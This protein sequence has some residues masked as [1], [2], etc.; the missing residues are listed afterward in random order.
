M[1]RQTA[2][3]ATAGMAVLAG[4]D[5]WSF[6]E[7]MALGDLEASEVAKP[8]ADEA[9][10]LRRGWNSERVSGTE[11]RERLSA[12]AGAGAATAV[13]VHSDGASPPQSPST[14]PPG[15]AQ[16]INSKGGG[17]RQRGGDEGPRALLGGA[18]EPKTTARHR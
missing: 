15:A 4:E 11:I 9:L 1:P 16:H 6:Q 18:A 2:G 12:L 5:E 13:G 3:M 8:I 17:G 7:E 14:R 10:R